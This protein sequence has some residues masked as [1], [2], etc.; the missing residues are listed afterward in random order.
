MPSELI[1]EFG[2]PGASREWI[3]AQA[4]LAIRHIIK[5]CGPPPPEM[6]LEVQWQEHE[7]GSY[8]FI[9]LTWEDAMRGAPGN[10]LARC[11]AALAAF[12]NGG[13]LPPG[14]TMPTVR[15]DDDDGL[16]EPFDPDKPPPEPPET[17]DVFESQSYISKL[18]QWSLEASERERNRPHL[19]EGDDDYQEQSD[20]S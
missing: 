13:E 8:P 16:D 14:W 4:T 2:T 18:I 5:V 9:A 11:E 17:L 6:E 3:S 1:G 20:H 10:Y 19:V 15:S 7:L 12:E